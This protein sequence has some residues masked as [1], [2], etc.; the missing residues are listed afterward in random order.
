NAA[1]KSPEE[2]RTFYRV[3]LEFLAQVNQ[4]EKF[5]KINNDFYENCWFIGSEIIKQGKTEGIFINVDVET[6]SHM[7]RSLID[8]CLLQWLMRND[9]ILHSYYR[10]N[11][12][13]TI[14]V[15]LNNVNPLKPK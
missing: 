3:Y 14:I 11:C 1:F 7:I 6:G 10:D 12:Y 9:D 2:N 15:Y 13:E 5:R 4:N 8:G